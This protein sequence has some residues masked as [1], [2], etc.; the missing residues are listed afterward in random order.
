MKQPWCIEP[1]ISISHNTEGHYQLC[2]IAGVDKK[3]AATAHTMTP[4]EYFNSD[5]MK[6]IRKDML[7]HKLTNEIRHACQSCLLNEA[8][9]MKSRRQTQAKKYKVDDVIKQANKDPLANLDLSSLQYVNLKILGNLCNLKCVM[10]N[11]NSSSKI[12]AEFKKTGFREIEKV[13]QIPFGD[14]NSDEYLKSISEILKHVDRFS[15]IGGEAFINPNFEKIFETILS[16]DNLNN[17]ELFVITNGTVIPKYVLDNALRFKNIKFMFSIDGIGEKG[18]YIRSDLN[19]NE[20]DEN[21]KKTLESNIDVSVNIAVQLLNIG[22][23]HEIYDYLAETDIDLLSS[24]SWNNWVTYPKVFRPLNVPSEIKKLYKNNY[25]YHNI[26]LNPNNNSQFTQIK[27]LLNNPQGN[28]DDFN[29]GINYL[30]TL[31]KFRDR[32]LLDV[33]PEFK[34]YYGE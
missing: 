34:K 13:I 11:Q 21:F 23:L 7:N 19:W 2:C 15:L 25:K 30:K 6:V 12:A 31:D 17:L 32:C 24:V 3:N 14:D 29:D 28:L 9:G 10:C 1:F 4:T 16:S 22:Y 18:E 8:N 33:F 5:Y 26:F 20:F 27:E